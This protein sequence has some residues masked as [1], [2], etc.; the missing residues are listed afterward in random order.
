MRSMGAVL[1]AVAAVLLAPVVAGQAQVQSFVSLPHA[2]DLQQ[3]ANTV[4]MR[5]VAQIVCN[6]ELDGPAP[7]HVVVLA[8]AVGP[9]D[10][11]GAAWTF[12]TTTWNLT[13]TNSGG[14]Y[15]IDQVIDINVEAAGYGKTGI[16]EEFSIGVSG[17]RNASSTMC[18]SSGYT[19]PARSGH[20][21][22]QAG[23][24]PDE[25]KDAP[26][27]ALPMLAVAITALARWRRT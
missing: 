24:R 26:A 9:D 15:S 22:I 11:S 6:P 20:A 5:V 23:A 19:V 17:L 25:G 3:G 18:T 2:V 10:G 14:N 8:G 12:Q 13:W 7:L 1:F 21:H 4:S 16:A 27:L